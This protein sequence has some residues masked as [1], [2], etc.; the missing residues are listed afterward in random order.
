[1]AIIIVVYIVFFFSASSLSMFASAVAPTTAWTLSPPQPLPS[2]GVPYAARPRL[3][4]TQKTFPTLVYSE[5]KEHKI[6]KGP[7]SA[8]LSQRV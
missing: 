3:G 7:S 8:H 6:G 4:S 5:V 2:V 1:M